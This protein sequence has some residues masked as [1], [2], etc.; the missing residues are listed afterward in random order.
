VSSQVS[1]LISGPE[2]RAKVADLIEAIRPKLIAR[3][4]ST[5]AGLADEVLRTDSAYAE[6]VDRA[7]LSA[8]IELNLRQ[9]VDAVQDI[10]RGVPVDLTDAALTGQRRAEQGLPLSSL[11]SAYQRGGRLLWDVIVELAGERDPGSLAILPSG[12][13]LVWDA[14]DTI[15]GGIVE[16]YQLVATSRAAHDHERRL[17]LVDALLDGTASAP[18]R[19][20]EASAHLNLPEY[21]RY[22]VVAVAQTRYEH[23]PVATPAA[24][25]STPGLRVLWRQ[26]AESALG[27]ILLR[28]NDLTGAGAFARTLGVPAGLSPV[29]GSLAELSRARWLAE[30]ALA[31]CDGPEVTLFDSR[32]PAALV[33]AQSDLAARLAGVVLGRI[34]A[35]PTTDREALLTTLEA[36]LAADGSATAASAALYCHRNTVFNR[37]RRLETLSGRS[38][39]RPHDVVELALALEAVRQERRRAAIGARSAPPGAASSA[40]GSPTRASQ[41]D[42][43]ALGSSAAHSRSPAR[44]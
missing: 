27:I 5:A 12:A 6:L 7:E 9:A 22:A 29:V 13:T 25:D 34:L 17:A 28:S 26:H 35:L 20:S 3:F 31:T 37:I 42:V 4:P 15:T 30:L 1:A 39:A 33:A 14:I 21:G 24:S 38:L 2:R 10:A 23:K 41:D 11:L 18:T 19:L 32:I 36:W 8:R 43:K 16:S 44:P 40:S